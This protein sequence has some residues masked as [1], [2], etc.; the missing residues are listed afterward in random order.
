MSPSQYKARY[1]RLPVS[2]GDGPPTVIAVNQYR[3]RS[4]NYNETAARAFLDALRKNGMDMV[5]RINTPAGP[6]RTDEHLTEMERAFQK[7]TRVDA[8]LHIEGVGGGTS[9]ETTTVANWALLA[10]YVF[11]GKGSP[12]ACQVVLQLAYHW[13]LTTNVQQYANDAL[14]LD[15]NGFVGNYLWHV[16]K[17]NPW[18]DLGVGNLDL[19]PDAHINEYFNGKKFVS[20]WDEIDV[21]QTYIL[22]MVDNAGNIIRGGPGGNPGHF[23]ITEAGQRQDRRTARGGATFAIRV[24]ESTGA[25]TPGLWE[26]WY[27][28]TGVSNK[29]FDIDREEMV[30]AHRFYPFKIAVL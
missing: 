19:G 3:L 30:R 25:H 26:S 7:R 16:K 29:I 23:A 18:Y 12:E 22:G 15:C 6:V 2:L 4:M 10:R 9:L 11:A 1:D 20:S 21:N 8:T 14:G 28:H 5:L 13:E 24:V 17:T 27:T